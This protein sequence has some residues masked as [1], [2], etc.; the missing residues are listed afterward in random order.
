MPCYVR[1]PYTGPNHKFVGRKAILRQLDDALLPPGFVQ[2]NS[3]SR[4]CTLYGLGGI[5]KTEVAIEFA[6][7]REQSF[8]AIFWVQADEIAKLAESFDRIAR[9]LR[10]LDPTEAGDR[11]TSRKRVL[12]WLADPVKQQTSEEPV[13]EPGLAKWLLVFDNADNLELILD[14][15][16]ASGPGSILITSRDSLAKTDL[17]ANVGIEMQELTP[18]DSSSLLLSLVGEQPSEKGSRDALLLAERFKGL[19]LAIHQVAA[20]IRRKEMTISEFLETYG[21]EPSV[22]TLA[23]A[24]A[25]SHQERDRRT[26]RDVWRLESFSHQAMSLLGLLSLLDPD[27]TGEQVLKTN[28]PKGLVAYYPTDSATYNEARTELTKSSLIRRSKETNHLT[29]HRLVQE[30]TIDQMSDDDIH[31]HFQLAIEL[32]YQAWPDQYDA[33]S[34]DNEAWEASDEVVSHVVKIQHHYPRLRPRATPIETLKHFATLLDSAG[35]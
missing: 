12:D 3:A 34:L 31:H 8:D 14:Y 32:L 27:R 26:L 20:L 13:S 18:E 22:E 33:Q 23:G 19:P 30:V 28:V 29:L 1:T 10:L 5:G 16:P 2:A 17:T 24:P 11:D 4:Y 7:S 15:L 25:I 9:A 35:W 21:S 6:H